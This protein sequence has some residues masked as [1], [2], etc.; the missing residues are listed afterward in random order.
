[1][2]LFFFWSDAHVITN[3]IFLKGMTILQY[4]TIQTAMLLTRLTKIST[5][6]KTIGLD[7]RLQKIVFSRQC[8]YLPS[9]GFLRIGIRLFKDHAP[10]S[11]ILPTSESLLLISMAP[12]VTPL[13]SPSSEWPV[14]TLNTI[15]TDMPGSIDL[16][17]HPINFFVPPHNLHLHCVTSRQAHGVNC[18]VA[19][20]SWLLQ[21][22][23]LL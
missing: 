16:V 11:G 19:G 13:A 12:P 8:C 20:A 21:A 22:D 3:T 14:D 23:A 4:V 17:P 10:S 5:S 15:W 2:G 6:A 1:M 18:R 7:R 9:S